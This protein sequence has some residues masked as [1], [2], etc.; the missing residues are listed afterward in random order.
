MQGADWEQGLLGNVRPTSPTPL[1]LLCSLFLPRQQ[2]GGEHERPTSKSA[3][4]TEHSEDM[5]QETS[6]EE[7][8]NKNCIGK[9]G[10]LEMGKNSVPL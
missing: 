6:Y 10:I 8:N 5:E 1:W 3:P 9:S 7:E 2:E 4:S